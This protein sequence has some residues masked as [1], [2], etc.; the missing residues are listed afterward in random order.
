MKVAINIE[1]DTDV[2]NVLNVP[3]TVFV[4]YFV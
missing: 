2:L 4:K 3:N 1:L